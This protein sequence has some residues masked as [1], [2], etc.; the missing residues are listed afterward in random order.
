MNRSVAQPT[1]AIKDD[2]QSSAEFGNVVHHQRDADATPQDS[3][4]QMRDH[5]AFYT[6]TR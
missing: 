5:L 6:G 1:V 2:Q 4:W 3:I